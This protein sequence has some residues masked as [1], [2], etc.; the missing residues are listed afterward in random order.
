MQSR[1]AKQEKACAQCFVEWYNRRYGTKYSLQRAEKVFAELVSNTRWEFVARQCEED[2]EWLA[3]EVKGLVIPEARRQFM[4]WNK[5][6]KR[7]TEDLDCRLKGT[8]SIIGVP[9]LALSQRERIQ[10]RKVVVRAVLESTLDMKKNE[11]LDL[12]LTILAQ[13][14]DWPSTPDL[15]MKPQPHAVKIPHELWLVKI[16]DRGCSVELGVSP[17]HIFN[18]EGAEEEAIRLVFNQTR[19]GNARPNEQLRLAKERGAKE[20]I[21]LLDSHLPLR[22]ITIKQVLVN[23]DSTLLSD[24]DSVYLVSVSNKQVIK[25]WQH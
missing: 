1:K 25:V 12:G 22:P 24:I 14:P 18:V 16:S 17:P 8:F 2:M 11:K 20:T 3:I 6:F 13:F 5:F 4:D 10:L 15:V 23:T 19:W 21:L 7:V 9:P